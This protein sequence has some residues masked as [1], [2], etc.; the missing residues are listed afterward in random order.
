MVT[1]WQREEMTGKSIYGLWGS[2]TTSWLVCLNFPATLNPLMH[3]TLEH[4]RYGISN[5][6]C[7]LQ[8]QWKLDRSRFQI[9]YYEGFRLG[10]ESRY[11]V[12]KTPHYHVNCDFVSLWKVIRSISGHKAAISSLDFH[13]Y[14]DI[15][16]S[17]SMDTNLKVVHACSQ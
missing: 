11:A 3:P 15:L 12:L 14:G 7:G 13:G 10:R 4:F 9:W 6:K 5:R 1:C 2:Q 17:G 8:Q 16:A